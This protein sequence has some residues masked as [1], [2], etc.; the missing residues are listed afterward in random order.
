MTER[1]PPEVTFESWVDR[2]I[3]LAQE[4]GDFDDLPGAGKPIPGGS[5]EDEQWWVTGYLQRENLPTDA[6]LPTPLQLRRQV[7]KLPE[8]VRGLTAEI[9]VRDAVAELNRQIVDWIR[10]PTGPQIPVATVDAD[11]VVAQWRADREGRR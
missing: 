4:R 9:E 7:E 2:Q 11:E 1:K 3:R 10:A 5:I 8:A 6:L